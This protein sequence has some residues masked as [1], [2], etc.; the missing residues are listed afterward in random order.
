[1]SNSGKFRSSEERVKGGVHFVLFVRGRTN[2]KK[3]SHQRY[4]VGG[5]N[6]E[7]SSFLAPRNLKKKKRDGGKYI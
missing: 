7:F 6:K 5:K 2:A 1:M 4:R 3:K